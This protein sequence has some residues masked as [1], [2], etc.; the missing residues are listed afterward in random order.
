[1]RLPIAS[2]KLTAKSSCANGYRPQGRRNRRHQT[3]ACHIREAVRASPIPTTK[4]HVRHVGEV[5][6]PEREPRWVLDR[7]RSEVG[8]DI[9][10]AQYQQA[11]N[12]PDGLMIK[13]D[14]VR[15]YDQLPIGGYVIQ[16]W[17]TASKEGGQNDWSVCTTW[18][19]HDNKYYL[20]DLL[21][22]RFDYPTLK[23]QAIS[24]AREHKP[25]TILIEDAG[26][27]TA[28]IRELQNAGSSVI[29]VKPEYDKKIRMAIQAAK[30]QGGRVYWP[31]EAPW[32]ADLEAEVFAFPNARHDDQVD[33]ISQALAYERSEFIWN[34]RSLAGL[35]RFTSALGGW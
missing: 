28:L 8:P 18:L 30:F 12:P 3:G 26:V 10:A 6:Q 11:P 23:A 4:H 31:N 20:I 29:A 24:L 22:G 25:D 19:L 35:T 33:S 5:L 9:W 14:W 13:R 27:G 15:R 21:R 2:E 16:S 32:L 7:I 17:D 1:M 34:E